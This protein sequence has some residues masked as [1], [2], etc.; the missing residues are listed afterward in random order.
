MSA[1]TAQSRLEQVERRLSGQSLWRWDTRSVVAS[2]LLAVAF[3]ATMQVTERIDFALTGGI[4]VP[5]GFTFLAVWFPVTVIYF[6]LS[7]A[8]LIANFNPLIAILTATHPLAWSFPFLNMATGFS[9]ALLFKWH[10]RRG[11]RIRLVDFFIYIGIGQACAVVI[12]AI[13]VFGLVLN[14]TMSQI[15]FFSL[16][17][18]VP[19]TFVAAPMAYALYHAVV[20]SRVLE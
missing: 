7:G 5:L 19:G 17:Q 1:I 16:L 13:G 10:L 2:V 3:S 18:W 6:G 14:L 11:K 8:V 12:M 20:R 4:A 9:M 15:L